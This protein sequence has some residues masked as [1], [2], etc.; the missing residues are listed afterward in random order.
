MKSDRQSLKKQATQWKGDR[1]Q[2]QSLKKQRK[3]WTVTDWSSRVLRNMENNK[4]WHTGAAEARKTAV[5]SRPQQ[6]TTGRYKKLPTGFPQ[7]SDPQVFARLIFETAQAKQI[8]FTCLT[9]KVRQISGIFRTVFFGTHSQTGSMLDME[10]KTEIQES[11]GW[12]G[13]E[14]AQVQV[15]NVDV[16][17]L[18]FEKIANTYSNL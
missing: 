11:C 8:E 18:Q 16:N 10:K 6:S 9:L 4:K 3:Q 15:V 7:F 5:D 13:I 17:S 14:Q 1:L 12:P 2:Q